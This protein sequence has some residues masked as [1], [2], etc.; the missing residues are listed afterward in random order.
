[1]D[2]NYSKSRS[3]GSFSKSTISLLCFVLLL[4]GK[5]KVEVSMER[6]C[7]LDLHLVNQNFQSCTS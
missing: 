7:V 2:G 4:D 3:M 5:L 6:V 1:M